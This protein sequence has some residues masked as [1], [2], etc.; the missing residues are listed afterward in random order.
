MEQ[1][2]WKI[3][4]IIRVASNELI[5]PYLLRGA[6]LLVLL[7]TAMEASAQTAGTPTVK[8]Q[9]TAKLQHAEVARVPKSHRPHTPS[10]SLLAP[11]TPGKPGCYHLVGKAW[12]AVHCGTPEE[13]KA[14]QVLP[15]MIANSIQ[16]TPHNYLHKVGVPPDKIATPLNWGSVTVNQLSDP[17][18]AS[19]KDSNGGPNTFS[20]QN[21]TN[22]FICSTCTSGSPYPTSAAG[23]KGWVQFIYQQHTP[24]SSAVC[25]MTF[26]VKV[27][28]TTSYASGYTPTCTFPSDSMIVA[29]L[30]GPGAPTGA[31]EI[32]GYIQCPNAGSKAGCT[33]WIIAHLPWSAG[34][35]QGWWAVSTPDT[36]GLAG[37]W[38]NVS[39]GIFGAGT[40]SKANFKKTKMQN[41]I[42]AYSCYKGS[43]SANP[44]LP[45]MIL[46]PG[47]I[48]A[49][50]K[51]LTASPAKINS[52]GE[53]TNLI[54]GPAT[55]YCTAT[56]CWLMY[57]STAR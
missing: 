26:D 40:G 57:N 51:Q 12:K 8:Q 21:N 44:P 42:R 17:A 38:N 3:N 6:L 27:A 4:S 28:S 9:M 47:I 31:A 54:D 5:L 39:G 56:S 43:A 34:P 2:N 16:S 18:R 15:A 35:D 46:S 13:I 11:F 49:K 23:D 45:C 19:E 7:V 36:V 48:N 50:S 33:L 22:Q 14:H 25:V 52:T 55:F 32:V 20:I 1:R 41:I 53:S 37:N 24:G 10:D 29:P 30:D